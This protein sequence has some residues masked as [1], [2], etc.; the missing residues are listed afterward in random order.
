MAHQL[1]YAGPYEYDQEFSESPGH[2]VV[3]MSDRRLGGLGPGE[4]R[5]Q[6]P[7]SYGQQ[8]LDSHFPES[9]R[10]SRLG[11]FMGNDPKFESPGASSASEEL[12]DAQQQ[13]PLVTVVW[14]NLEIVSHLR[15]W[16]LDVDIH[17]W[18]QTDIRPP[19]PGLWCCCISTESL[20]QGLLWSAIFFDPGAC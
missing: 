13:K 10:S 7:N 15:Y 1:E 3:E 12:V 9:P 16:S 5:I 6:P 2:S 17:N 11:S 14:R 18:T 8:H 4:L 19:Q 20:K